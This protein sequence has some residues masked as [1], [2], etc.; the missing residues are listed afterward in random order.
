[1]SPRFG[2]SD[3]LQKRTSLHRKAEITP[4]RLWRVAQK[5]CFT[6]I[7]GDTFAQC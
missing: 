6:E 1:M 3:C 2:S 7:I 4:Y 5:C